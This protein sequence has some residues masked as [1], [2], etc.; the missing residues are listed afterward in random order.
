MKELASAV[1]VPDA[2][3]F[4]VDGDGRCYRCFD[5]NSDDGICLTCT[6]PDDPDSRAYLDLPGI[7]ERLAAR[8]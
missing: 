8:H 7:R 4:L 2:V 6:Y 3:G 1:A 5:V